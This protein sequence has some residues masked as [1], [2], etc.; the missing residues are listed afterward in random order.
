MSCWTGPNQLGSFFTRLTVPKRLELRPGD[1]AIPEL[2]GLLGIPNDA[3]TSVRRWFDQ[4]LRGVNAGIAAENPVQLQ[5]R[6][7]SGYEGYPSW[8]AISTGAS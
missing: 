1:H 6:G 4:Y 2:T 3:W 7:Q 5:P 8:S